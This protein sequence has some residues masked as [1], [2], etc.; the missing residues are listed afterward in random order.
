MQYFDTTVMK[1]EILSF[2]KGGVG[3]KLFQ[4]QLQVQKLN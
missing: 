4:I 3:G 2:Q 1:Q